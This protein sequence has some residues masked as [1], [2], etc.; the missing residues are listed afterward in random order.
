[1]YKSIITISREFGSSGRT[2]G[3]MTAEKLGIAFYDSEIIQK[4]AEESGFAPDYVRE[5]GEDSPAKS[6]FSYGFVGRELNG[7][8]ASDYLWVAQR[9]VILELAEK[10]PCVI[11]GRC[12]D[13]IL[14][15]RT[16]CLHVFI[17]ADMEKRKEHLVKQYGMRDESPEKRLKDKDKKRKLYY[18]FYTE[19]EWGD[20]RN[21]HIA[22]DSGELGIDTCVNLITS[23]VQEK[24]K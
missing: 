20:V 24:R 3:R 18:R 2:V 1:M 6:R 13:Y 22:L 23:L 9:K 16:D 8:A 12:A 4:V 21:Y 7:M 14:K 15:D 10:E 19:R 5:A 11:V 17:H